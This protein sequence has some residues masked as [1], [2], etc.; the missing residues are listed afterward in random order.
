LS[1]ATEDARSK[2][3]LAR[4]EEGGPDTGRGVLLGLGAAFAAGF[5]SCLAVF[6]FRVMVEASLRERRPTSD[7]RLLGV[8]TPFVGWAPV[9]DT[10]GDPGLLS[11]TKSSS[12]AMSESSD[13]SDD[14]PHTISSSESS[15]STP[16]EAVEE[17]EREETAS[18][19]E[20]EDIVGELGMRMVVIWVAMTAIFLIIGGI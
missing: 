12:D 10:R 8:S 3:G 7:A 2:T 20:A 4:E 5:V 16:E 9:A 11:T 14:W 19:D 18:K 1:V 15:K 17:R 13:P 6:S